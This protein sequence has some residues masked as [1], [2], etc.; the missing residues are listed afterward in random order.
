MASF[1]KRGNK[2]ELRVSYKD[3]FTQKNKI[4]SKGGFN[5]KKEAQL[6]AAQ[7]EKDLANGLEIKNV[8]ISLKFYL[9][10][11]LQTFKKGTVR[12]NTYELHERNIK[13]HIIP[14][15]KD[16]NI[17]DIK[18]GMYQ[19]FLN[20]LVDEKGYSKRTVEIIHGT[21]YNAM[22]KA[23]ETEKIQKNPCE[24]AIVKTNKVKNLNEQS[25]QYIRTEDLSK[26]LITA[27]ADDYI[28]YIFFKFLI[29]TGLRK[30]EAAALQWSDIDL[31]NGKISVNK[32]LDFQP[33]NKNDLFGDPKTYRSKREISVNKTILNDLQKHIK[34]QN[35]NKL[36]LNEIY[37]HELNLV[38]CKKDGSPLPKSTLFNAFRRILKN[39]NIQNIPIHCL[40]HTHVVLLLEAGADMKYIQERLGH[41]SIEITSDV[42]AHVSDVMDKEQLEKYEA[43]MKKVL[44]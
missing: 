33:K 35:H 5:T 24:G 36:I 1:R 21:M 39:A 31:K 3:P 19:K 7:L 6:Y 13:N 18:L 32:T 37:E 41:G 22:K 43:Y 15:F 26:F 25:L 30:G 29:Y 27:Y 8:P 14:Y 11:W 44:K 2:W 34:W 40:R 38:F 23:T 10:D 4:K 9:N 28:Y 20:H 12:K 16:I 17:S 42:Y